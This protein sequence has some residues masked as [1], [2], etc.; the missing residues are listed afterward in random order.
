[1]SAPDEAQAG[2]ATETVP[3]HPALLLGPG[4]APCARTLPGA[5]AVPTRL[6]V[7]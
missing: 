3:C 2:A 1:M 4:H 5:R 6:G 7:A